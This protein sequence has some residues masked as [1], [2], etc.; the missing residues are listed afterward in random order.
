MNSSGVGRRQM[1]KTLAGVSASPL[2]GHIP[3][4]AAEITHKAVG[5]IKSQAPGGVYAPKF[6]NRD[7]YNTLRALCQEIVP[8]DDQW[9]GALEAGAPEFIDLLTSENEEYQRR[10]GGGLSWLDA[11]CE[12]RYGKA[13]SEC[14]KTEQ[15]KILDLIAYRAQGEKERS[16]LPGI[17]FFA[18]LR[19]LTVDGYFTSEIGI[20]YL[21]YMGNTFVAEFPGCPP[22][23]GS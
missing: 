13:Y 10:L 11:T 16:L 1:L 5:E 3:L 18:F 14:A 20:K 21:G 17:N 12:I 9:G 19:E 23:P 6:F 4:H 7:D 22:I 8:S 2:V 15:K